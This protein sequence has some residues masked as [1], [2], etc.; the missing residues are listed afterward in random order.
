MRGMNVN[1]LLYFP[2]L[3]ILLLKIVSLIMNSE[4]SPFIK[5]IN[6]YMSYIV[7]SVVLYLFNDAPVSCYIGMFSSYFLPLF[8]VYLGYLYSNDRKYNVWY[9]YGCAF[10][11]I[12]GFYLYFTGPSYYLDFLHNNMDE[13]MGNYLG[14]KNIDV[15][16]ITR[17]SSYFGNSY[18]ISYFSVPALILALG[19]TIQ[20]DN[21][22]SK[23][24]LYIIALVSFL[25]AI[26]CQQRIAIAFALIIPLFYGIYSIRYGGGRSL[27]IIYSI[28]VLFFIVF[29]GVISTLERFDVVYE[30]LE[31]KFSQMIFSDALAE[32][33]NQY[34]EFNRATWWSYFVGLG[35]GACSPQALRAGLKGIPDGEFVKMF[36]E[37]GIIGC[38]FFTILLIPTLKRGIKYFKYYYMEVLIV[39]FFLAAGTGSDSLTMN[40]PCA[41]FWYSIGRIWNRNYYREL[42]YGYL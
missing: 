20:K 23:I 17:F 35:M 38:F 31:K 14:S 16:D 25:A 18:V 1:I 30:L 40:I 4:R 3:A 2:A 7:L 9:M 41:M 24:V 5:R 26:L 21:G 19:N 27:I 13:D 22:S 28:V 36:Y 8:F 29:F 12:I 32:R 37:I 15:L 34:T 11:F 10:C 33:T 6:L 39:V 42:A